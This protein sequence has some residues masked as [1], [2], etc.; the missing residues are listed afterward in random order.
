MK[1]NT[2]LSNSKV[3]LSLLT[4]ILLLFVTTGF[5]Q[6]ASKPAENCQPRVTMSSI[7]DGVRVNGTLSIGVLYA[8]CLPIADKST[9]VYVYEPYKGAKFTSNLKNSSGKVVNSFAW[10]GRKLS[11]GVQL[12][13][14][15]IVGGKD[16]LKELAA[17]D[18]AL[19]FA[20]ENKVFQTFRFSVQTKKSDDQYRP[21]MIYL[22][23]GAWRDEA[24]L[25]AGNLDS[26]I[27]FTF[28]LR[29]D[30][31]LA[32]I[33]PQS[34]PFELKIIRDTDKKTVAEKSGA[35]LTLDNNWHTFRIF[36]DRPNR[37]T[38][39]DY[40]ALKLKEI[41]AVDGNYTISL[42]V[43][44]KLYATY[45]FSVNNGKINGEELPARAIRTILSANILRR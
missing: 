18:Y 1:K 26:V 3:G 29:A 13:H 42:S 4:A 17:G 34:V 37:E 5:S 2:V 28:R 11:S 41:T 20:I 6:N 19:E 8:E 43:D 39:K 15:E 24:I 12:T 27:F 10:Y 31:E 30:Y 9:S 45:K 38:T 36:F 21:G 33:K 7:L 23:E 35:K 16:A 22:L 14:Y 44:G 25:S 40:S 32:A